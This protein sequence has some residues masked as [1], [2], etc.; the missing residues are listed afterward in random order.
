MLGLHIQRTATPARQRGLSLVEMMVGLTVGLIVVAGA[1][2][3]MV[4][5]LDDHRR[6]TLETQ[7]QQDL[8]AAA[9]LVLRDLR[10]AAYRQRSED[11][12]WTPQ[13]GALL[14]GN[15][16]SQV[17]FSRE[18][19][20]LTYAYSRAPQP[21]AEDNVPGADERYGFRVRDGTLQ[22]LLG[23]AWQPLTDPHTMRV[24]DFNVTLNEQ[25]VELGEFCAA[26]CPPGADCPPRQLVR[27]IAVSLT[28]TATHDPRVVRSVRLG[29]RLRN[30]AI[31]G[32]CQP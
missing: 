25:R 5:Q 21:A 29:A 22:F 17:S 3:M 31:Q 8:R 6:L 16:F 24:S 27:D 19:G 12:V 30:D 23:G 7:V 4:G 13:A 14:Q 1:S 20:E 2:M 18:S 32:S 26:P 9:D 10:R 15:G 11:L 28:G